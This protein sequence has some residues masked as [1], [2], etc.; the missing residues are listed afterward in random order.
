MD[1]D[2]RRLGCICPRSQD[3]VIQRLHSISTE[4]SIA[5]QICDSV[6]NERRELY[7]AEAF[8]IRVQNCWPFDLAAD[9]NAKSDDM[10]S[11]NTR[12]GL[13]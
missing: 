10:V 5:S 4:M 6:P 7:N 13:S 8:S 12:V 3:G 11:K 2:V 9:G 1:N